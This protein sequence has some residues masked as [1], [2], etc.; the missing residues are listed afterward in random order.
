MTDKDQ[1]ITKQPE[2]QQPIAINPVVDINDAA[3]SPE[4]SDSCKS[5][6]EEE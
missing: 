2:E 4:F 1:K 5:M 6:D 3:C